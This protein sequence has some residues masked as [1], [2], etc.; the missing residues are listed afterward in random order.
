MDK[1]TPSH[2]PTEGRSVRAEHAQ[3]EP[4]HQFDENDSELSDVSGGSHN[5][6]DHD[7]VRLG[8]AVSDDESFSSDGSVESGSDMEDDAAVSMDSESDFDEMAITRDELRFLKPAAR[9][10]RSKR[11]RLEPLAY[12][13]NEHIVYD[14]RE[15]DLMPSIAGYVRREPIHTPRPKRYKLRD[16][17]T[18][19]DTT[20]PVFD[21]KKGREIPIGKWDRFKERLMC[22]GPYAQKRY[23][24]QF[25]AVPRIRCG[26][27]THV[28]CEWSGKLHLDQ[29]ATARRTTIH[30]R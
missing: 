13:R 5:H 25:G 3:P 8:Y 14:K 12:W 6:R 27:S 1:P 15:G 23:Y 29:I 11:K 4:A 19:G 17:D 7:L 28:D 16:D 26:E 24:C 21:S 9:A 30:H 22:S 20:I 18:P 10:P 2:S